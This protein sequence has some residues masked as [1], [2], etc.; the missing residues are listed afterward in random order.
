MIPLSMIRPPARPLLAAVGLL[1]FAP[2][3]F[4]QAESVEEFLGRRDTW[5]QM[6]EAGTPVRLEGRVSAV[7]GGQVRLRQFPLAVK[8]AEGYD[9][10]HLHAA[11]YRVEVTGRL[12][13]DRSRTYVA[14]SN[15]RRLP[16]DTLWYE[17]RVGELDR[18][19]PAAWYAL[20]DW[21]A[22]RAA[23][24]RDDE[25]TK[26]ADQARVNGFTRE[27]N[28]LPD[29]RT[30]AARAARFALL[31]R[32]AER[33]VP[34]ATI[35]EQTHRVLRG[36]WEGVRDDPAADL[37][38]LLDALRARL[39]GADRPAD[40]PLPDDA[41]AAY[42]GDPVA[43]YA[44]ADDPLRRRL[45]RRFFAAVARESVERTA[46]PDGRDGFAV[47]ARFEALLPERADLA[48]AARG[49]ELAWRLARVEAATQSEVTELAGLFDARG[50]PARAA[51]ARTR[52]L[53]ARE[54]S[55]RNEG[56]GGLLRAAELHLSV[57]EDRPAAV[58]LLREAERAAPGSEAVD[59]A[60]RAFGLRRVDGRWLT[61]EEAAALPVDPLAHAVRAG[62]VL[63]GMTAAQVRSALGEPRTAT[64]AASAAHVGEAWVYGEAGRGLVV[65]LLRYKH[66][67]ADEAKVVAVARLR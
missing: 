20:A 2:A 60:M 24:Y 45:H 52:W 30:D 62:R 58:R 17:Q 32:A 43:A 3:A 55:L 35:R 47:A 18:D 22:G 33:G 42:A 67:P 65:H 7:T 29:D 46:A 10:D 51:E 50:E 34:V 15:V 16:D 64:R 26:L 21:A 63:P 8:P 39:P 66:A 6:L 28:A 25:L 4:G 40:A 53:S 12:R 1:L 27:W 56:V 9:F 14:A 13:R 19:D 59:E 41:G 48:A 49:R 11:T 31:D 54:A 37:A 5:E 61:A 23:F 36:W 44:A 38:P 57:G